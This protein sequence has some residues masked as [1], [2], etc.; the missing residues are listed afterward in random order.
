MLFCDTNNPLNGIHA[1][2]SWSGYIDING[3][4]VLP[5]VKCLGDHNQFMVTKY[6]EAL[7]IVSISEFLVGGSLY[8]LLKTTTACLILYHPDVTLE[9]GRNNA[10][11]KYMV[12]KATSIGLKDFQHQNLHPDQVLNLWSKLIKEDIESR[13]LKGMQVTPN[14]GSMARGINNILDMVSKTSSDQQE[15]KRDAQNTTNMLLSQQSLIANLTTEVVQLRDCIK[16]KDVRIAYLEQQQRKNNSKLDMLRT[17]PS[18]KKRRSDNTEFNIESVDSKNSTMDNNIDDVSPA[19]SKSTNNEPVVIAVN[20][21]NDNNNNNN[22]NNN[23]IITNNNIRSVHECIVHTSNVTPTPT[24]IDTVLIN[25]AKAKR[26][27]VD[28]FALCCDSLTTH[29]VIAS[30][31]KRFKYCMELSNICTTLEERNELVQATT[32]AA[33]VKAA[34]II[35]QKIGRKSWVV[36]CAKNASTR[37]LG[38]LSYDTVGKRIE[39][40]KK[41]IGKIT[42]NITYAS[43]QVLK[44]WTEYQSNKNDSSSTNNNEE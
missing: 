9:C 14:V 6:I 22:N 25:L 39:A 29:D 4:D 16:Q 17:P 30:S 26:L 31:K 42:G 32:D 28:D 2:R 34:K 24:K 3:E 8:P 38:S 7:H 10:I 43:I 33:F 18:N 35:A 21:N 1:A 20:T 37:G 12:D 13:V 27:N 40:A 19:S 5:S 41:E 23:S 36:T 44:P 15:M 11:S